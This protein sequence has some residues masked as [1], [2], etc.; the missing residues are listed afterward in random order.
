MPVTRL[1]GRLTQAKPLCTG[2]RLVT[3]NVGRNVKID[4]DR[5]GFVA[6]LGLNPQKARVL[7]RLALTKTSDP[8]VIQRYFDEY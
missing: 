5:Y 8:K 1:R 3:G 6:S 7:L 4:D 2:L